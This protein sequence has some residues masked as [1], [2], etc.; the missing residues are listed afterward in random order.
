MVRVVGFKEIY[1]AWEEQYKST[2]ED[3]RSAENTILSTQASQGG[4]ELK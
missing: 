1:E 3:F 2:I 4:A